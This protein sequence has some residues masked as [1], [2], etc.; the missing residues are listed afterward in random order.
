[1]LEATIR[2]LVRDGYVGCSTSA[3]QQEAGVS[4]GALTHQYHSK[5]D[6]LIAAVRHLAATRGETVQ[7]AAARLPQGE[8]RVPALVA[9]IWG[10]YR[11]DLFRASVELWIAA[12]TDPA[13]HEALYPAERELG[14]RHRSWAASMLDPATTAD[15]AFDR[16]LDG[17]V[18]YLRGTALTDIL[19]GQPSNQERVVAT[20]AAVFQGLLTAR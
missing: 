5:S 8:A 15:P 17:L 9:L 18:N 20:G 13:L 16:A 6:L 10:E 2:C 12:R 4:R 19:R 3:I 11:S 7:A 1:V 14:A